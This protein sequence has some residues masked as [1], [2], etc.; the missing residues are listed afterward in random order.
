M[1]RVGLLRAGYAAFAVAFLAVV[2]SLAAGAFLLVAILA[3][4]AGAF[5]LTWSRDELPK[6]A[7]LAM[8]GYFALTLVAFAASTPIT[9][10]KGGGYFLNDAPSPVFAQLF[11]YIGFAFPVM[12]GATA[13]AATWERE[14]G[15]RNLL[16]ASLAGFVLMAL[17]TFAL[18]PS[19]PGAAA[20]QG[21]LLKL[22]AA[23]AALAGVAGA[24]WAA[25]RPDEYA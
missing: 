2:A 18:R 19:S 14:R 22:L 5:L 24:A 6:W 23:A 13:L 8:L 11:Y 25:A 16:L 4:L 3:A 20:M 7:G 21:G 17:L 15:V 12:L 10:N 1:T 9:I